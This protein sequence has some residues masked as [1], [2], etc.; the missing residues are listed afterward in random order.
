MAAS[1]TNKIDAV[2]FF[3]NTM[4]LSTEILDSLKDFW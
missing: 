1:D 4:R 3:L 2:L